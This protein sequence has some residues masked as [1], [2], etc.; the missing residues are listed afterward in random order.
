MLKIYHYR[1]QRDGTPAGTLAVRV[2]GP[3]ESGS[4]EEIEIDS[5]YDL[6]KWL[7]RTRERDMRSHYG[8]FSIR[9]NEEWNLDLPVL[10]EKAYLGFGRAVAVAG[11]FIAMPSIVAYGNSHLDEMAVELGGTPHFGFFI[12][13]MISLVAGWIAAAVVLA[14]L[15]SVRP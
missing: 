9:S 8:W 11:T 12:T 15:P 13:T 5:R 10:I 1:P 6:K 4:P 2:G 14:S 7:F 3:I